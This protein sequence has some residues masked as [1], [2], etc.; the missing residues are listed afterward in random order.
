MTAPAESLTNL[1]KIQRAALWF[2]TTPH[3]QRQAMAKPTPERRL[4]LKRQA[5]RRDL[6]EAR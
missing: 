3:D 2:A 6:N 1:S 4:Y 5:N